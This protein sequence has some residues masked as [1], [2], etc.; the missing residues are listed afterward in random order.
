MIRWVSAADLLAGLCFL[1]EAKELLRKLMKLM[2]KETVKLVVLPVE[3]RLAL[4]VVFVELTG[5]QQ[6]MS[7]RL[8]A[9]AQQLVELA[10]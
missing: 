7:K 10:K 5:W 6:G 4:E 9:Q 3:Q 8:I 1:K 2:M